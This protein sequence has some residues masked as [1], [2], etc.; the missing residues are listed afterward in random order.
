[1][2]YITANFLIYCDITLYLF[3]IFYSILKIK[4]FLHKE[5]S[6]NLMME[7]EISRFL[8]LHLIIYNQDEHYPTP[9][10]IPTS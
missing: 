2:F 4:L 7:V 3:F 5:I 6:I 10:P 1:M 8:N 9:N